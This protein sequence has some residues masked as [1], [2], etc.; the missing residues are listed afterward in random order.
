VAAISRFQS[1]AAETGAISPALPR[2]AV[3][4]PFTG[5]SVAKM[6]RSMDKGP[7]TNQ[8]AGSPEQKL[9]VGG[10]VSASREGRPLESAFDRVR[11]GARERGERASSLEGW[12]GPASLTGRS[13]AGASATATSKRIN[14]ES[15]AVVLKPDSQTEIFLHLATRNGQIEIQARF[16]RGDF[17]G[18][19]GHWA[20]LQQT[21]AQQGVR[22]SHL[23]ENF[24]QTPS[25]GGQPEWGHGQLNQEQRRQFG[26]DD[27]PGNRRSFEETLNAGSF[28][29]AR[30]RPAGARPL[31]RRANAVLEAWA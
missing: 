21:L 29:E 4:V 13:Q 11:D 5:T 2:R 25:N 9:P 23:Q 19:S 28:G 3:A 16:E 7:E 26:G 30:R 8:F 1:F 20:Q 14:A 10:G 12:N 31:P 15:M 22:L 17:A 18:L 6:E 24:N 27:R